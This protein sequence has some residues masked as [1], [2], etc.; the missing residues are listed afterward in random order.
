MVKAMDPKNKRDSLGDKTKSK[1]LNFD[2]KIDDMAKL[3][4]QTKDINAIKNFNCNP[5][6]IFE[7]SDL[8]LL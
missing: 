8:D 4:A 1:G 6:F 7:I 5:F 2:V 3:I